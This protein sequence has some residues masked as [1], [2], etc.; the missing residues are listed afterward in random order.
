MTKLFPYQ[1][2]RKSQ[3][4]LIEDIEKAIRTKKILLAHAPTGLGKTASVL[5]VAL[6]EA[7]ENNKTIFFLTN[8]HTQHYI[9]IET[10]KEIK[11]KHQIE[12]PCVDLIGK[13][14]MC[15]QEIS[16]LFGVDFTEFCKTI[17][18]RG[19]CEFYNNFKQKKNLTVEAKL[20]LK[21]L[22]LKSPLHNEELINFC[23]EK[24]C[25]VM[26]WPFP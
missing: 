17:V 14:W 24:K 11:T 13:R 22:K 21:E 9:A 2:I 18:E 5:S 1:T 4:L 8:R 16:S 12:V 20:A 7:I 25:V 6:Q 10:L 15:N 3:D 23:K 26:K 19:E